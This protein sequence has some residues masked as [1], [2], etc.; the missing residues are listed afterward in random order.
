MMHGERRYYYGNTPMQYTAI[1]RGCK[2]DNL[3]MKKSD[4]FLCFAENIDC[5]YILEPPRRTASLF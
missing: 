4:I 2:T 1:F 5:G 3:M